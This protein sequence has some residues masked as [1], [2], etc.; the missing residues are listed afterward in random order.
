MWT[1]GHL[2]ALSS[3]FFSLSCF[4]I[5]RLIISSIIIISWLII[6][7]KKNTF[8]GLQL[9]WTINFCF[10]LIRGM[11]YF[12]STFIRYIIPVFVF[13]SSSRITCKMFRKIVKG[14]SFG[15]YQ[16]TILFREAKIRCFIIHSF[17]RCQPS[18]A[19]KREDDLHTRSAGRPRESVR[20]DEV[21]RH[22]YERRGRPED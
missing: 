17:C 1:V 16:K 11:F 20:E 13:V 6:S 19:A 15:L 12:K 5:S 14:V 2:F 18:E 7:W 9:L 21:S 22:I 4:I 8:K 10:V 3:P